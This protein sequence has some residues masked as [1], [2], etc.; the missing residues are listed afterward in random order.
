[1]PTNIR[2]IHSNDF[3]IATSEGLLDLAKSR[4]LL[5]E[6][7]SASAGLADHEMIVDTRKSES[8]MSI[9]D[10]WY[11]ATG[12]SQY[13]ETFG[14]KRTAVVC[15][16]ENFDQAGFF[17]LVAQNRGCPIRAFTSVGD[18]VEW[19]LGIGPDA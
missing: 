18:A 16:L 9:A 11:L 14:R 10:L 8:V 3:I 7:A 6:V 17:A 2:I 12:L 19:L 15:P 4:K 1:L 13:R 5:L